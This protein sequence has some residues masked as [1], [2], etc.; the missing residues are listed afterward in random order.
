MQKISIFGANYREIEIGN[1]INLGKEK[2]LL[3][4]NGTE[5]ANFPIAYQTL[6]SLI[7]INQMQF[8]FAML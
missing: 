7:K 1:I 8:L 6:G 4:S 5:I 3:L 2:P